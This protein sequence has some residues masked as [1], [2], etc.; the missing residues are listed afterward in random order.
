MKP[1]HRPDGVLAFHSH[2]MFATSGGTEVASASLVAQS[3]SLVATSMTTKAQYALA[4][5]KPP[6]RPDG[7]L[8]FTDVLCVAPLCARSG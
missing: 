2:A 4:F 3:R 8:T 1:P 5:M 7:V 6:H